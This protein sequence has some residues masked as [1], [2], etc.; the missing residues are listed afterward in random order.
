MA[1]LGKIIGAYSM[2]TYVTVELY[3]WTM[4]GLVTRLFLPETRLGEAPA[5]AAFVHPQQCSDWF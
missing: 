2:G 5:Q 1:M 4:V 3:C